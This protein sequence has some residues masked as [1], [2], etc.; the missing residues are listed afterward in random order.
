[1][2]LL[3][4]PLLEDRRSERKGTDRKCNWVNRRILCSTNTVRRRVLGSYRGVTD[5]LLQV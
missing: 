2:T 4:D 3:E 1:M 5:V